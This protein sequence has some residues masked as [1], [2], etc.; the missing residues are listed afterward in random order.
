MD[1][2]YRPLPDNVRFG[3]NKRFLLPNLVA[4]F[5]RIFIIASD[6]LNGEIRELSFKM[7]TK[8]IFHFNEVIQHTPRYLVDEAKTVAGEFRDSGE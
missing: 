4:D 2:H 7:K 8:K 5:Q 1:F 3:E 6:R